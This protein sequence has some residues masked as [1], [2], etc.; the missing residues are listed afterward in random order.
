MIQECKT[1]LCEGPTDEEIQ[2][3]L[4]IVKR[5]HI[6]IKLMWHVPHSGTYHAMVAF[7]STLESVKAQIPKV[8]GI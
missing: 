8:Y 5:D 6:V 3:A 4:N 1:Y 7:D 2:E